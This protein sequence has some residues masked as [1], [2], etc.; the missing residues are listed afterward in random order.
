MVPD[1]DKLRGDANMIIDY[2]VRLSLIH[3]HAAVPLPCSDSAV[4]F[5]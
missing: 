1:R 3:T 4:S 2:Q 5:V